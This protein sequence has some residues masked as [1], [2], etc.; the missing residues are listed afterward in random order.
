VFIP[1]HISDMPKSKKFGPQ[2][3]ASGAR[4]K[5]EFKVLHELSNKAA[6]LTP[7]AAVSY[8]CTFIG[9]CRLPWSL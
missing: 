4:K 8:F 2:K 5:A 1:F 6:N 7:G 3:S 9:R